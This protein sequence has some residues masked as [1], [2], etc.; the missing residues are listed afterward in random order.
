M[1][2]QEAADI[3]E[4][5]GTDW[6]PCGC[7]GTQSEHTCGPRE[8]S[9]EDDERG[10]E[11]DLLGALQRSIPSPRMTIAFTVTFAVDREAWMEATGDIT[12]P[13]ADFRNYLE[14]ESIAAYLLDGLGLLREAEGS[15]T[16]TPQTPGATS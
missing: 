13:R 4:A 15:V 16:M 14:T 7:L 10:A 12:E 11:H 1:H 6:L 8:T 2:D 5:T 3:I 9:D